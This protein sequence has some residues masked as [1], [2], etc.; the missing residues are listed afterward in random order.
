MSYNNQY[1]GYPYGYQKPNYSN[2]QIQEQNNQMMQTSFV[3]VQNE[4]EA[5]CYPVALGNSVM[6]RDESAPYIYAKTMGKSALDM[7]I[8]EKYRLV[9]EEAVIVAP[10]SPESGANKKEVDLSV[11]ALKTEIE[12]ILTLISD[13]KKELTLLKRKKGVKEAETDDE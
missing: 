1:A 3:G 10:Q 8:F 5:R 2:F 4:Q 13:M 9:K 11:Y 12:P 6:F 7:P